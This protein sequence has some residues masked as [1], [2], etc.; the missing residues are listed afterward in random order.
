[1]KGQTVTCFTN[2]EEAAVKLTE[3]MPFL[4]ET[5]LKELGAKFTSAKEIFKPHV[6]VS[7]IRY[8]MVIRFTNI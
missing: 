2:D 7:T 4:V 1:M 3:A 8:V 5:R 6:V